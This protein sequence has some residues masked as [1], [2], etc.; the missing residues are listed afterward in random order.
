MLTAS[1]AHAAI[2]KM[3]IK[4]NVELN[5]G[6]VELI[7]IDSNEEMEVGWD[8]VQEKKCTMHCVEATDK[9]GGYEYKIA[10]DLGASM[11]Y[12]PVNGQIRIE[13]K[14][15]S[16][17]PVLINVHQVKR[18]CDAEACAF[19]DETEKGRGLVFKIGRFLSIETSKDE[20]YSIISG[21]T[22]EGDAFTVKAVWWTDNNSFAFNCHKH[23]KRYL[24]EK[25]PK[26]EYSPYILSGS[27]IG[28]KEII[29]RNVDTCA[30][31]APH[32]GVPE[33]NVYRINSIEPSVGGGFDPKL[34]LTQ[35]EFSLNSPGSLNPMINFTTSS[36]FAI[37]TDEFFSG[38]TNAL[39]IFF[40]KKLLTEEDLSNTGAL[41]KQYD[42]V[43]VLFIDKESKIWQVN[44]TCVIPWNTRAATVAWKPD[45]LKQYFSDYFY[46]GEHLK[47]KTKGN[48]HDSAPDQD[49]N[50]PIDLTWD[51]NLDIPVFNELDQ[52]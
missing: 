3:P 40:F 38:Q 26:E 37:L 11:K 16:D 41:E 14:N 9:S 36:A 31:K 28:F 29:L 48:Y 21:I 32:F 43:M 24:D 17:Q 4:S 8:A 20:S 39:E 6:Q 10:T 42:A 47:L 49:S 33:E 52:K 27:A 44:L 1:Y 34:F 46:D 7:T 50:K 15:I 2:E 51:I 5:P 45:E 25:T 18:T 35:S 12:R 19:I 30:P 23:I 13:Y 22:T